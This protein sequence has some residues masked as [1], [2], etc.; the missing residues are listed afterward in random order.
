MA[1][2]KKLSYRRYE[3]IKLEVCSLLDECPGMCYP[4]KPKEIARLLDYIIIP[5]SELDATSYNT[6]IAISDDAYS[7]VEEDDTGMNRY[8]IYYN[9]YCTTSERIDWSIAHEIGHIYLGH[10]DAPNNGDYEL[11][12]NFFA[13]YL[14]APPP[15][16]H[17]AQCHDSNDVAICFNLSKQ[18]ATY[19]Y[20]YY[21]RWLYQGPKDYQDFEISMIENHPCVTNACFNASAVV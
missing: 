14:M 1:R 15:I 4:L 3:E 19:A 9:D 17:S 10:H 6:A 2:G 11:E 13:K 8:V 7:T 12:A 5:Y 21:E 20:I 16:I 18:A